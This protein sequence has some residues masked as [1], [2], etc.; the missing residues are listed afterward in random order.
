[1]YDRPELRA[2]TDALWAAIRDAL[3]AQGIAAPDGLTRDADL[4]AIWRDPEL[5]L[6]QT[7]GLPFRAALHSRVHLVATPDYGLPGCA[8]GYYNS[9]LIA[10][11]AHLPQRPRIA[12]NDPLSQSGWAALQAW[13]VAQGIAHDTVS[14]T[15]A[16][17]LSVQA[18]ASGTA[19]L[20]AI[21]AQT[22]RL[23]LRHGAADPALEIA[24]TQPTP[25]L[26]LITAMAQQPAPIRSALGAAL[27]ALPPAVL[28]AL[29]LQGFVRIDA[30]DYLA[31]P[32]PHNP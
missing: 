27:D 7:C 24:R 13:T 30:A 22:W 14:I 16:H 6:A 18:V 12:I 11:D 8:P 15:G 19:D 17:A 5:V 28:S 21:D 26:P 2:A 4:W 20:A 31:I 3:R 29:D 23:L 1:M 10:R 25:G 9:V 32:L